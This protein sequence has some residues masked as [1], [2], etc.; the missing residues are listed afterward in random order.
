MTAK[1]AERIF[2]KFVQAD[3]SISRR[4]GGTGLGLAITKQLTELMGGTIEVSSREG[5]GSRFTVTLPAE[6]LVQPVEPALADDTL[7][8]TSKGEAR[9]HILLA[10]DYEGNIVVAV[11]ML[12]DQGYE[13][14]VARNGQEALDALGKRDF[15]LILM[16][17]QMP[18]MDGY[19]ATRY[20][21]A[22]QADGM[23]P[24][25]AIIG[26]TANALT[27]DRQKCL[28]AGMDDYISKPFSPLQLDHLVS[29]YL[30][31][32]VTE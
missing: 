27:G 6:H 5:L 32:K 16:D 14:T 8:T 21:R 19:E 22:G 1:Q 30:N 28:D 3:A 4:F 2:D 20:I 13:V 25:V 7:E 9:G 24:K 17:V 15:D 18:V 10:E 23:L 26:V 11:S 31:P 29:K 12:E